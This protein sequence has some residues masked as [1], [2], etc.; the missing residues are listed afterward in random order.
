[1]NGIYR[2]SRNPMYLGF[3]LLLIAWG[4]YLAHALAVLLV[5]PTFVVY[6]NRYQI[7][8]EEEAL[9]QLFGEDFLS[10]KNT[11]GRWL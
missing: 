9:G 10:Y 4:V 6:L 5:P 3:V 1:M 11:V 7:A 2:V 8:P